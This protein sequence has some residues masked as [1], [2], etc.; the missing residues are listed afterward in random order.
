MTR[1]IMATNKRHPA[2]PSLKTRSL[3][4]QTPKTA[5]AVNRIEPLALR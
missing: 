2:H 3:E 4:W 1:R 5:Q